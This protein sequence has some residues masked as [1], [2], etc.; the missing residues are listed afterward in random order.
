MEI[1]IFSVS[2]NPN[3]DTREFIASGGESW[4]RIE[5]TFKLK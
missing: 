1:S 4:L 2:W 3:R 5:S